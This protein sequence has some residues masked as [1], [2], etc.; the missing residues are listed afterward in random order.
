MRDHFPLGVAEHL[1]YYVYRLIDPRN[2]ETFYVGKGKR[3]RIFQH[4]LGALANVEKGENE[5][6]IVLKH[7][8]IKDIRAAGLEVAHVIHRHGIT[9]PEVAYE[10]EAALIEAYPGLTNIA[11]GHGSGDY[12]VR[13]VEEIITEYAA[14][15]FEPAEPLILISIG[16]SFDE[17]NKSI[18]EAVRG[19]WRIDLKRAARYRLVIAHRRGLVVGVFRPK[20]WFP[21]TRGNFDFLEA[22]IEGRAGFIGEPAESEVS[23]YY[24]RKRVP[25]KYRVK[26]AANPVRFVESN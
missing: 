2:G 11:G 4:A 5:D 26:G 24:L 14:Q 18:Y 6:A 22:D 23:N 20:E 13:H 10:V 7:Q 12:G 8:R 19:F 15:P 3:D 16:R 25:E 1:K 17:E 21:A 9:S